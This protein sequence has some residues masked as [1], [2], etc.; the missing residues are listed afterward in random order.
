MRARL[1]SIGVSFSRFVALILA[2]VA[3]SACAPVP[4]REEAIAS[5]VAA[6]NWKAEQVFSNN[7]SFEQTPKRTRFGNGLE[8]TL[9]KLGWYTTSSSADYQLSYQMVS[10]SVPKKFSVGSE[11]RVS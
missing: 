5:G 8:M 6:S 7:I 9:R 4:P 10:E 3:L 11:G 1:V 2:A